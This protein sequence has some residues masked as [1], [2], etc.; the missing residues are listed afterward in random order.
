MKIYYTS[1]GKKGSITRLED[2]EKLTNGFLVFYRA[3]LAEMPYKFT[4][5]KIGDY[6]FAYTGTEE[7][8]EFGEPDIHDAF[9][10]LVS[11]ER[12]FWASSVKKVE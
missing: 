1:K 11:G 6:M 3:G 7:G 2:S 5:L 4:A 10:S 9:P 8:Y 12:M